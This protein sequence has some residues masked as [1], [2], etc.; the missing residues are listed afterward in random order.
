MSRKQLAKAFKSFA[1]YGAIVEDGTWADRYIDRILDPEQAAVAA[2]EAIGDDEVMAPHS[3][4]TAL[5]FIDCVPPSAVAAGLR[6]LWLD[7]GIFSEVP[8]LVT[9]VF[10]TALGASAVLMTPAELARLAELPEHVDVF[11]GQLHGDLVEEVSGM[12]WTLSED[13]ADWYSAPTPG[14]TLRGRV[15]SAT[16][17]RSILLALFLER[18]EAEVVIDADAF[19]GIQVVS[20]VGRC[21][22]FPAHLLATKSMLF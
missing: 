15:L 16:V 1:E 18:G 3:I 6:L 14:D 10:K 8:G 5:A 13:V 21:D 12:S 4:V 17:P 20:R 9:K 22:K 7:G 11:R 19:R 2:V